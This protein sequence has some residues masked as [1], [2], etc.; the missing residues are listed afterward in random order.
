ME[1]SVPK[2]IAR[3]IDKA[4]VRR[5]GSDYFFDLWVQSRLAVVETT[6]FG[7]PLVPRPSLPG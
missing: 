7:G 2:M 6:H 5:R 4:A 3:P 1:D